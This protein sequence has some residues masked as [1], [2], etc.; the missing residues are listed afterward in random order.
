MIRKLIVTIQANNCPTGT[1]REEIQIVTKHDIYKVPIEAEILSLEEFDEVNRETMALHGQT[2]QK[3]RVKERLNESVAAG[4]AIEEENP[5]VKQERQKWLETTGSESKL[6][7]IP[8]P[9]Q[10]PFDVDPKKTLNE[11]IGK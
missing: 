11:M 7:Q 4:R 9:D 5:V 1:L 2:L 6:P 3:S 8:A 10:R